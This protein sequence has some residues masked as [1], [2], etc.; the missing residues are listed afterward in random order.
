MRTSSLLYG[1]LKSLTKGQ[2][3]KVEYNVRD[4]PLKIFGKINMDMVSW[5]MWVILAIAVVIVGL[6]VFLHVWR[7][8]RK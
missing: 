3:S 8:S 1:L 4:K 6:G 5:T 2:I 7:R